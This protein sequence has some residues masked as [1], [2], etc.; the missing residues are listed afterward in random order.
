METLSRD[1]AVGLPAGLAACHPA[2]RAGVPCQPCDG[3]L[4]GPVPVPD[5]EAG[6]TRGPGLLRS[7]GRGSQGWPQT[8]ES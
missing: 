2:G 1:N 7:G 4:L 3:T 5:R 6:G 8:D